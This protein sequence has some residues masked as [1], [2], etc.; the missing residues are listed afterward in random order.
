MSIVPDIL[1]EITDHLTDRDIMNL[2]LTDR[3]Y[4]W[5][6]SGDR[7]DVCRYKG[8]NCFKKK[9][10]VCLEP[11]CYSKL[12]YHTKQICHD[13][14][15]CH[16]CDGILIGMLEYF[17]CGY[18]D[19]RYCTDHF[20]I[21]LCVY[22]GCGGFTICEGC[23]KR[24]INGFKICNFCPKHYHR[25]QEVGYIREAY[26]E[27]KKFICCNLC[28]AIVLGSFKLVDGKICCWN[29]DFPTGCFL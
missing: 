3:Y 27:D 10:Q 1:N 21:G 25:V 5:A 19:K 29:C 20:T 16:I 15:H 4:N 11:Y 17:T 18:C 12:C 28:G 22:P 6:L 24:K 7:C 13:C 14:G 26:G 9:C 23:N 2:S 8:L